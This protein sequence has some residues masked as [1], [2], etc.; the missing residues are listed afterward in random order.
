MAYYPE[1]GDGLVMGN[2]M[3]L[4]SSQVLF[5]RTF[6]SLWKAGAGPNGPEWKGTPSGKPSGRCEW[7]REWHERNAFKNHQKNMIICLQGRDY[8][9]RIS[10]FE[11]MMQ[12]Q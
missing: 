12:L 2:G 7:P 5:L 8:I 6:A 11:S 4:V 1:T 9:R 3:S 10:S